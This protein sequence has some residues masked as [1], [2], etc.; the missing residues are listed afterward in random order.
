M[1]RFFH[2]LGGK[3]RELP[4]RQP[5]C[6]INISPPFHMVEIELL[7]EELNIPLDFLTDPLDVD[8]RARFDYDDDIKLIVVNTPVISDS[9]TEGSSYTTIPIGIVL[10]PEHLVTVCSYENV[11][12]QNF[13]EGKVRNFDPKDKT[14]FVLQIFEQNVFGFLRFL[15]DIN[16]RSNS[17]EQEIYQTSRNEDLRKLLSIE[18]SLV[19]F[20]TDLSSNSVLMA[21]L[22]RIDF[23]GIKGDEEKADLLHDIITEN[24]QA[25]EMANTYSSILATTME[26]LAS[27]ISNN[28][29]RVMQRLTIITVVLMLPTLMA[30]FYGMNV[31]LPFEKEPYMF[32]YLFSGALIFSTRM[33]IVFR[34]KKMF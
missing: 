18:K 4:Q 23:L 9:H 28:L 6:W 12:L 32:W 7:A 25:Q 16:V 24:N 21:K 33:I 19:Y 26:A 11:V 27:M 13:M 1:I 30:S 15:K 17:I 31:E 8:E 22:Q 29:N 10:S 14:L 34:R 2:K 20:V 5:G 3:V